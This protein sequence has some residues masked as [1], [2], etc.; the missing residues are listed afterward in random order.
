MQYESTRGSAPVLGFEEVLLAGLARDGGLYVPQVWPQLSHDDIAALAGLPYAEQALRVIG[1]FIGKAIADDDLSAMVHEAYAGFS[2]PAVTPLVQLRP[3]TWLLELFHG[4]TLAF[5]D[6]AM[7]LLSRMVD[8]ELNRRG[9][10]ATII[11]AT[12]GDTGAAAV[13]GFRGREATDLFILHPKG[14]VSDVQR[15]QM[16]TVDDARVHNIAIEGTFDDCQAIVKGLFND[17]EFRDRFNVGGVNS[18]N[19]AR[20]MAQIVYYFSAAVALGAPSRPVSFVVPTGNFGDIYAGYAAKRMGL[21]VERLVIATNVNDILS[22]VLATGR[23]EVGDVVATM[24]P[25]MDIQVSSNFERVLYEGQGR[26]AQAVVKLMDDLGRGGR[27][28]LSN[29]AQSALHD[30]FDAGST[31]EEE[32][33]AEIRRTFDETGMIVDPHTAVGLALARESGDSA[34]PVICLATAH[35]AKFAGAV[36]KACG[37]VAPLPAHLADLLERQEHYEVLPNSLAA[38]QAHI[39]ANS[40]LA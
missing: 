10:R 26:D 37:R 1:P 8:H 21:P 5:K 14:R 34:T 12:S 38:V 32:T 31:S 23:Y 22:R 25:S 29:A 28:T 40:P 19:W 17:L 2:H 6:V 16:T 11:G 27:F 20:V 35:P 30:D 7:Q 39:V 3:G 4:P 9:R 36:E 18:I 24:S 15:R 13:E 33:S